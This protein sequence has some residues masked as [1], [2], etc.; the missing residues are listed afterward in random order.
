M[1][2]DLLTLVGASP[3]A[4]RPTAVRRRR[5][6]AAARLAVLSR[7]LVLALGIGFGTLA[8]GGSLAA[9]QDTATRVL[10][11][12][13]A[14]RLAA[15]QSAGALTARA[16]AEQATA[17]VHLSFS[18]FLPTVYGAAQEREFT[19]NSA[20]LFRFPSSPDSPFGSFLPPGGIVLPPVKSVDFRGYASDTLFSFGAIQRYRQSKISERAFNATA[21]NAAQQ[22]AAAAATAYLKVQRTDGVVAARLADS[23]LAADL[24]TIARQQLAAGVGVGLDVTR[25]ASQAA[26]NHAQL[27]AARND[28]DRARLDLYRALG[29]PLDT[30]LVLTDSLRLPVSDSLP[31]ESAAIDLAMRHRPDLRSAD[32]QLSASQQTIRAIRAERLPALAVFGDKGVNG[33]NWNRLLNTYDWGIGVSVPVFDGAR[34]EARIEEQEAAAREALVRRR[35]LRQ[36][37]AIEVRGAFLDLASARQQ[38]DAVNQELVLTQQELDQARERFRT[39]VAGNADVITASLELNSA[40]TLQVDAQVNYQAARVSLANATGSVTGLP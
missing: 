20:S 37:A 23:S 22:A 11:L 12:G 31:S 26:S 17:R 30:R 33:G 19:V 9:Q 14:A 15:H 3:R 21:D 4:V 13:G 24:L 40:R 10:T 32:E 5:L 6:V 16:E 2:A 29:L 1:A 34:R 35:D 36:Q 25:A 7:R 27:I 28:R 8:H 39:G 38:L 18:S